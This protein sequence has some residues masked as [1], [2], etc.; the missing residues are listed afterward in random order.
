MGRT[1]SGRDGDGHAQPKTAKT[2]AWCEKEISVFGKPGIIKVYR[3]IW[4][5][6]DG[7]K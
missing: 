6:L 2:K 4:Y 1:L 3:F 5:R 7:G